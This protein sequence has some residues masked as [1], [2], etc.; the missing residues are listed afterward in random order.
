[1]IVKKSVQEYLKEIGARGGAKR[2]HHPDRKAMAKR[3]ALKRWAKEHP[4]PLSIDHAIALA[5][6]PN[7]SPSIKEAI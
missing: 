4:Q 1:M 2:K 6:Y 5:S 3:A 7:N